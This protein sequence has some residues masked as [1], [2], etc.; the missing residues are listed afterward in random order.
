MV[1]TLTQFFHITVKSRKAILEDNL[2]LMVCDTRPFHASQTE[3]ELFQLVE[4]LVLE[5]VAIVQHHSALHGY[6]LIDQRLYAF[7]FWRQI[8]ELRPFK[9]VKALLFSSLLEGHTLLG[10]LI[11][12]VLQTDEAKSTRKRLQ[13]LI[14]LPEVNLGDGSDRAEPLLVHSLILGDLDRLTGGIVASCLDREQNHCILVRDVSPPHLLDQLV[15]LLSVSRWIKIRHAWKVYHCQ[16]NLLFAVNGQIDWDVDNGRVLATDN[17]VGQPSDLL[18]DLA[19]IVEHFGFAFRGVFVSDR[20][21]VLR[22]S[23]LIPSP[24][25]NLKG[26]LGDAPTTFGKVDAGYVLKHG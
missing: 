11:R 24:K 21:V 1:D 26:C 17:L 18:L 25:L 20:G 6:K 15:N 5:L 8:G 22:V 7:I 10:L 23:L 14:R 16:V 2:A 19:E 12:S 9:E 3:F 4:Q 13:R